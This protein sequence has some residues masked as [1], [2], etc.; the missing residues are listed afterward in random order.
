[1]SIKA[2]V[3]TLKISAA[4]INLAESLRTNK[5]NVIVLIVEQYF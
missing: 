5:I 1:M 2:F 3:E 4:T